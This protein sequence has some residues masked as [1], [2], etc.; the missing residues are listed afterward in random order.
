MGA[1]PFRLLPS[2]RLGVGRRVI[3]HSAV[4]GITMTAL[5]PLGRATAEAAPS[6]GVEAYVRNA[7]ADCQITNFRTVYHG[8]I[9]GS[10]QSVTVVAYD[11][12]AWGGGNNGVG[13]LSIVSVQAGAVHNWPLDPPP[14]GRVTDVKVI[15]KRV[16]VQWRS[17]APLDPRCCPSV[18]THADYV[19][20]NGRAVIAK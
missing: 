2:G 1:G 3:M 4:L 5:G 15:R 13:D 17:W 8:P 12:G 10:A 11:S 20:R 6:D 16:S 7:N 18:V 14:F 9:Q 19:L